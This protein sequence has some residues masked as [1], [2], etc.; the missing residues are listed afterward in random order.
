MWTD[1][2]DCCCWIPGPPGPGACACGCCCC[3]LCFVSLPSLSLPQTYR[4]MLTG[5][6]RTTEADLRRVAT[7]IEELRQQSDRLNPALIEISLKELNME[8][9]ALQRQHEAAGASLQDASAAKEVLDVE[10]GALELVHGGLDAMCGRVAGLRCRVAETAARAGE[11]AGRAAAAKAIC[12][13]ALAAVAGL[14]YEEARRWVRGA[15]GQVLDALADGHGHAETVELKSLWERSRAADDDD[16]GIESGGEMLEPIDLGHVSDGETADRPAGPPAP[17]L[18]PL[19]PSPPTEPIEM[20]AHAQGQGMPPRADA[21]PRQAEKMSLPPSP[22]LSPSS[23]SSLPPLPL[24][25]QK[26]S[27]PVQTIPGEFFS[28][29]RASLSTVHED[30]FPAAVE[31]PSHHHDHH[32]HHDHNAKYEEGEED[33]HDGDGDDNDGDNAANEPRCRHAIPEKMVLSTIL[34]REIELSQPCRPVA[35]M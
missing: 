34:T 29:P 24:P 25:G 5:A 2:G 26:V 10:L 31:H 6:S 4:E 27:P 3:R 9:A 18:I 20:E 14:G 21:V 1:A 35:V 16:E 33:S 22:P 13:R 17:A 15:V 8:H 30:E 12:G 11:E 19:P 28:T 7:Q 32:D 23:S